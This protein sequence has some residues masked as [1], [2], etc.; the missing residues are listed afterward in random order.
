[1]QEEVNKLILLGRL[2]VNFFQRKEFI[3]PYVGLR[4]I[5]VRNGERFTEIV[6]LI[7]PVMNPQTTV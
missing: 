5:I 6:T 3:L 2:K 1:M 4:I 7:F